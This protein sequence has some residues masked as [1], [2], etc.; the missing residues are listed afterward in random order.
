MQSDNIVG[1][2]E[3]M[4]QTSFHNSLIFN[5]QRI[6]HQLLQKTR[7]LSDLIKRQSFHRHME[8]V[9]DGLTIS[10]R[11]TTK[12]SDELDN[13]V[14]FLRN[15]S[16]NSSPVSSSAM[17][18]MSDKEKIKKLKRRIDL[19]ICEN[20]SLGE[21]NK[22]LK[23]GDID[24]LISTLHS[25][26]SSL[27]AYSRD[28]E[29]QNCKLVDRIQILISENINLKE[30]L[31]ETKTPNRNYSK[32]YYSDDEEISA[33]YNFDELRKMDIPVPNSANDVYIDGVSQSKRM[34]FI[35]K[36]NE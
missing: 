36:K 27:E 25:R 22:R 20:E 28:L 19:L 29:D 6:S 18:V 32:Y 17:N 10:N 15:P 4:Q 21:E 12:I 8:E 33:A 16:G 26:I 35:S 34:G 14:K 3:H 31:S 11:I 24:L 23:R 5:I 13:M 30:Q 7:K 2:T 9:M 1:L